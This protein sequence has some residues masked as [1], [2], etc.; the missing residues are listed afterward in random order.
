MIESTHEPASY[1]RPTDQSR[2]C[3]VVGPG[4]AKVD[5]LAK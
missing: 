4:V 3:L 2:V 1:S 5:I